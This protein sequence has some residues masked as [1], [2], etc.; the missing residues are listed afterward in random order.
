MYICKYINIYNIRTNFLP[1]LQQSSINKYTYPMY[2]RNILGTSLKS[3][4]QRSPTSD[5]QGSYLTKDRT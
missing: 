2:P 3:F 1:V 5:T 4:Y